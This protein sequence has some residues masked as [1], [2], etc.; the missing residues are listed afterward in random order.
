MLLLLPPALNAFNPAR[1]P[2]SA[3]TLPHARGRLFG[4]HESEEAAPAQ[5]ALLLSG[6]EAAGL[7]AAVAALR[8]HTA[9]L[10]E[11]GVLQAAAAD[12][13]LQPDGAG[14]AAG[15]P[16]QALPGLGEGAN[17]AG[18]HA[19]LPAYLQPEQAALLGSGAGWQAGATDA[20]AARYQHWPQPAAAAAAATESDAIQEADDG[21]REGGWGGCGCSQVV[22]GAVDCSA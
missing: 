9:V 18:E 20:A 12:G 19:T 21:G 1:I 6:A 5:Q 17:A 16:L 13:W 11:Q 7:D 14:E 4:E 15:A 8:Q 10:E 3:P 22:L 2:R